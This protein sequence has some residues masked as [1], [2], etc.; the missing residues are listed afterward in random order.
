MTRYKQALALLLTLRGIP[1][2]YYGDEIGMYANKSVN[3]GA[4][5]QNFPGGWPADENNAFTREGRT[6][7]QAEYH[8]YTQRLLTWRKQCRTVC[9]GSLTHYTVR[10]GVYVYARV[11]DGNVVTVLANGTGKP[12][13]VD[14]S[15]YAE[16][17]PKS[18]AYEVVSGKCVEVGATVSLAPKQVMILDFTK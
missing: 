7:M 6:P 9:H 4:L 16:V 5:R 17:L 15:I 1:Q 10:G 18:E 12:A 3:D 13:D 8:D 11:L 14:T 2:L